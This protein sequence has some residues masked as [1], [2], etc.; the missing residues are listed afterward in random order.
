MMGNAS[1]SWLSRR[2][3]FKRRWKERVMRW[4][5]RKVGEH[6]YLVEN[7]GIGQPG[8]DARVDASIIAHSRNDA[9]ERWSGHDGVRDLGRRAGRHS[10][11][12][13]HGLS[14]EAAGVVERDCRWHQRALRK[15]AG[16]RGQATVEF[17]VIAAGFLV[18]TV[19]LM[20]LWRMIGGGLIVE[21][22]LAVASHHIQIV[23]PATIVDVFLY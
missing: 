3:F 4:Q 14:P 2:S 7:V 19:T 11:S 20:A 21:H 9:L 1:P 8:V 15:L 12:G 6:G 18:V 22:A 5:K 16:P 10:N 23:A 13:D 17:A